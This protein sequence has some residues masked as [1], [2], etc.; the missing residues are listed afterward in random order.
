MLY[1]LVEVL[2]GL[3]VAGDAVIGS[4]LAWEEQEGYLSSAEPHPSRQ[5]DLHV[6]RLLG[7]RPKEA[8]TVLRV[9]EQGIGVR[10]IVRHNCLERVHLEEEIQLVLV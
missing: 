9:Q 5:L 3:L 10:P 2:D 6:V 8:Q 1:S 4:L 7:P